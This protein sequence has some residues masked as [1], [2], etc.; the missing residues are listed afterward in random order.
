MRWPVLA[1]LLL[2]AL[3]AAASERLLALS[4]HACEMLFAIGAGPEVVGVSAYCDFPTAARRLPRVADSR[5]LYVEA[6]LRLSPTGM[7]AASARLR[8]L[9]FLRRQG[10]RLFLTHPHRLREVFADLRR[11]GA[12]TGHPKQAGEVAAAME[13]RLR[14]IMKRSRRARPVRVFFA[15]WTHPLMTEG[16]RSFVSDAIAAAGGRNVFASIARETLR[17]D[18]EA[19]MRARPEVVLV[20]KKGEN[21]ERSRRFWRRWLPDARVV[22]IDPDL[23]SR[24]GPRIVAGVDRLQRLLQGGR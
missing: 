19:V 4:P 2:W 13:K 20:P 9:D 21:L 1:F 18:I 17:I 12:W 10:V 7:V 23:I 15:S 22:V 14:T 8:G 11:L 24:P 16:G 5:R 3:P 6:A